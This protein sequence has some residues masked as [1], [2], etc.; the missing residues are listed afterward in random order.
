MPY[1]TNDLKNKSLT[2]D[3]TL[4]NEIRHF[5]EIGRISANLLH[6]ISN[7][8][9]A[10]LLELEHFE[11][12][13]LDVTNAKQSL[14]ILRRY[15]EAARKQVAASGIKQKFN[16]RSQV[17]EVLC[18]MEP[19][20]RSARIILNVDQIPN[21]SL[22]GDPV[23]FQQVLANLI[24]NA[25]DVTKPLSDPHRFIKIEFSLVNN[26]LFIDVVDNGQ[27]IP[28]NKREI[29]FDSFY[30]TKRE[31]SNGLG[32][33]LSIVHEYVT[34]DFNGSVKVSSGK[35]YGTVFSVH[36][37]TQKRRR[38][39]SSIFH[40]LFAAAVGLTPGL[41]LAMVSAQ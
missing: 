5:A 33:G 10:A 23:K 20:A 1:T 31:L 40:S 16:I 39:Q 3:E 15:V 9:T 18:V 7:P 2:K 29:I 4:F 22:Y 19:I 25:I 28:K 32:L 11:R 8:L 26:K 41:Y 13:K 14:N 27:G 36:F 6:E 30:S 12:N 34:S 24:K 35:Q 21:C 17:E 38:K 37:P